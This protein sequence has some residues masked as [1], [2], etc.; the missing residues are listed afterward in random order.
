M[1]ANEALKLLK[2]PKNFPI[3]KE[4]I[5]KAYKQ[6]AK[7]NHPDVCGSDEQMKQINEAHDWLNQHL[8]KINEV[9]TKDKASTYDNKDSEYQLKLDIMADAF[10]NHYFTSTSRDEKRALLDVFLNAVIKYKEQATKEGNITE[11][12]LRQ[13]FKDKLNGFR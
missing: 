5:S 6:Q 1:N 3:T 2:I 13:M 9:N 4:Q 8:N 7:E 10:V 11:E 12:T